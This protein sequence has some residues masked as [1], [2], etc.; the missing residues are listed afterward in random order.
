MGTLG[1][2]WDSPMMMANCQEKSQRMIIRNQR[3]FEYFR[4]E[5]GPTS[6]TLQMTYAMERE[7][8]FG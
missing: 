2:S 7:D 6:G 4:Y 8:W 3:H 5:T 1:Q